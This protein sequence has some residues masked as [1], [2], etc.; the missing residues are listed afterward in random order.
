[1][2]LYGACAAEPTSV[3][4]AEAR[5]L[6]W[7]AVAEGHRWRD[8][9]AGPFA[10]LRTLE[11]LRRAID[12]AAPSPKGAA[13]RQARLELGEAL[14][15]HQ[16][17]G[18]AIEELVRALVLCEDT[19]ACAA[20]Q[21]ERAL[22]WLA[23]ALSRHDLDGPPADA[24]MVDRFEESDYSFAG[25]AGERALRV[26]LERAEDAGFVPQDRA[27]VA[28]LLAALGEEH[29]DLGLSKCARAAFER[30]RQRF[31]THRELPHVVEAMAR[32]ES[33][34]EPWQ[35]GERS[36]PG[37]ARSLATWDAIVALVAPGSVWR[38]ANAADA[39][40]LAD[41]ARRA[42]EATSM[43]AEALAAVAASIDAVAV[44][45]RPPPLD[46]AEAGELGAYDGAALGA[47]P[48]PGVNQV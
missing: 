32:Y 6:A 16:R 48:G 3:E 4:G 1:M 10:T 42:R 20:S 38:E 39:D 2:P 30:L 36:F 18:A 28:N 26:G 31:P 41:G 22:T 17:Y 19:G 8:E 35:D 25:V 9:A 23:D 37:R 27:F 13:M 34:L 40:A 15:Q 45:K 5:A 29:R 11:A 47:V 24:P 12:A 33:F 14:A 44:S 43:S 7:L 21:R 46:D